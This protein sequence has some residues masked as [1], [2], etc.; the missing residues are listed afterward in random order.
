[1]TFLVSQKAQAGTFVRNSDP[2]KIAQSGHTVYR[3]DVKSAKC[4]VGKKSQ[5]EVSVHFL[6]YLRFK[7]GLKFE[8]IVDPTWL[9]VGTSTRGCTYLPPHA[10][11]TTL[12]INCTCFNT[13]NSRYYCT[14]SKADAKDMNI[15]E[16]KKIIIFSFIFLSFATIKVHVKKLLA[17]SETNWSI[18]RSIVIRNSF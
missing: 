11:F 17:K 8:F 14:A 6:Q 9:D 4:Q 12:I 10:N 5:D 2:S 16:S 7:L 3:Q 15:F 13:P 1:M 18:F